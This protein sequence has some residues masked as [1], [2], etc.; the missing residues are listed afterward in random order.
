MSQTVNNSLNNTI[1]NTSNTINSNNNIINNSNNNTITTNSNNNSII[2]EKNSQNNNTMNNNIISNTIKNN[3][4]NIKNNTIETSK[5][6]PIQDNIGVNKILMNE[7]LCRTWSTGALCCN[8]ITPITE[9]NTQLPAQFY[10]MYRKSFINVDAINELVKNKEIK[11]DNDEDILKI[12]EDQSSNNEKRVFDFVEVDDNYSFE[13]IS[14][15]ELST[16]EQRMYEKLQKM[17]LRVQQRKNILI[18]RKS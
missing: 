17:L 18:T 6:N 16:K 12:D 3:S 13:I 7:N 15:N 9:N 10:E 2:N 1:L 8:I 4:N 14:R 11:N 5:I